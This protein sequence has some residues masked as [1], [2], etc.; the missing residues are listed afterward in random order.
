MPLGGF[1]EVCDR[2]VWL[3]PYG[4][5]ENGH[6]PTKVR[7]VQQLKAST[8]VGVAPY[9]GDYAPFSPGKARFRFWWRHSLWIGWT[10]TARL[11]QLAGLRLHRHP[12]PSRRLDDRRLCLPHPADPHAS[13]RSAR[14]CFAASPCCSSS[15]R[16]PRS[17]TRST[18]GPYYRAVMFG[19][20]PRT[21]LPAPPQDPRL[22]P[23][24]AAP[25]AAARHR[26][27]GGRGHPRRPPPGRRPARDGR[28][29]RQARR[30][31]QGGAAQPHGRPDPRRA[32]H[33]TAQGR[34]GA[35]LPDLLPGRRAAH[36]R[37]LRPAV[38]AAHDLA[39]RA[40]APWRAPRPRSTACRRPST[41][42]STAC[43][44]TACSTSKARSSC[45]RRPST[46][47]TTTAR[48]AA[49]R[50]RAEAGGNVPR[51]RPP[52]T[53]GAGVDSAASA[54][55]VQ[56]MFGDRRRGYLRETRGRFSQTGRR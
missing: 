44:K 21:S 53:P 6:P 32:G 16:P 43:S 12:R 19:D 48:P 20:V 49:S 39:R 34:R 7:D 42:S 28:H 1:C 15:C 54:E 45:S 4:A 51:R 50:P 35:Q 38:G 24:A 2:W 10:F 33:Q 13:P 26:R 8:S 5:C 31:G 11:L 27:R 41:G 55:Q 25:A 22:L 36:R 23:P 3:T 18:C 17:P 47:T 29:H 9:E 40:R 46:W 14:R 30:A 52:P 37:R 56:R